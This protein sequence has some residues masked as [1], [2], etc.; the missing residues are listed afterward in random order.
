MPG[1]QG[2]GAGVGP[3]GAP[4]TPLGRVLARFGPLPAPAPRPGAPVAQPS[5]AGT[6]PR[7]ADAPTGSTHR[8]PPAWDAEVAERHLAAFRQSVR[9]AEA[10]AFGGEFPPAV[11]SVLALWAEVG[12]G[13]VRDHERLQ[14]A[15]WDPLTWLRTLPGVVGETVANWE[16]LQGRGR[17]AAAGGER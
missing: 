13:Y 1:V 6:I 14:A 9:D 2:K 17:P 7:T 4:G 5:G 15:G 8:P 16:R 12:A 11:A 3:P 10:G